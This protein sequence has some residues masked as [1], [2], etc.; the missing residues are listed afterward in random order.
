M[1]HHQGPRET[2][3]DSRHQGPGEVPL[4]NVRRD[5]VTDPV[6]QTRSPRPSPLHNHEKIKIAR[7]P[8]QVTAVAASAKTHIDKPD[9]LISAS[10]AK[11]VLVLAS[12]QGII[13]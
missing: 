5:R 12:E 3:R 2:H 4:I 11:P 13:P 9:V 7:P 8:A 10:E 6:R 1:N